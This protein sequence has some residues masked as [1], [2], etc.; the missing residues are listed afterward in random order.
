M[1][2]LTEGQKAAAA[3]LHLFLV[4]WDVVHDAALGKFKLWAASLA[5]AW[6]EAEAA[7]PERTTAGPDPTRT[8]YICRVLSIPIMAILPTTHVLSGFR[9]RLAGALPRM[10]HNMGCS[11]GARHWRAARRE[12]GV[13]G[14]VFDNL[15]PGWGVDSCEFPSFLP[16]LPSFL[17]S[18]IP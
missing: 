13:F 16:S 10:F 6:L 4:T 9:R 18:F 5:V 1:A 8:S 2:T 14:Q 11:P 17:P 12:E 3:Q 7:K 15:G